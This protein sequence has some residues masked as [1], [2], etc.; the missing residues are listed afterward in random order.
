[1]FNLGKRKRHS[2]HNGVCQFIFCLFM[3]GSTVVWG[4]VLY[5]GPDSVTLS[6]NEVNA[7]VFPVPI[8][9]VN[10]PQ[11]QLRM[12]AGQGQKRVVYAQHNTVMTFVLADSHLSFAQFVVSLDNGMTVSLHFRVSQTATGKIV[13]FLPQDVRTPKTLMR[14]NCQ[15]KRRQL[16]EQGASV[17]QLF[18]QVRTQHALVWPWKRI[19]HLTLKKHIAQGRLGLYAHQVWMQS[20]SGEKLHGWKVCNLGYKRAYLGFPTRYDMP[21]LQAIYIEKP[22]LSYRRCTQVWMLYRPAEGALSSFVMRPGRR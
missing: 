20:Q 18:S 17:R 21:R 12:G 6:A 2:L 5:R 8:S 13:H 19:M 3:G 16:V 9:R 7:L 1:M 15:N 11:G 22:V 4:A 14:Q 10:Y